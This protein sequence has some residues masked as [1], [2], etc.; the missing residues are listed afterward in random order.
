TG[1]GP[2][3]TA[4]PDGPERPRLAVLVVFDQLRGD[5]LERW[6]KLFV[7]GGFRRFQEEGAWF[8]NCH[9]PYAA[10]LTAAGHASMATG[11][12]PS[13]H[14]IIANEWY[15][16]T[17]RDTVHSARTERHRQVPEP[18]AATKRLLGAAPLRRRRP[19][20]ADVLHKATMGKAKLVSLS[21]KERSAILLAAL[22]R[23]QLCLWFSTNP[24]GFVTS[25]YYADALPPWVERFNRQRPADKWFGAQWT[26]LRPDLNYAAHSGPDDVAAEGIGYAQG[27]TFPH[28]LTGGK[29]KIGPDYYD[30]WANS[31]FASEVLLAL[32][33]LAIDAE[34]LGRD[35]VP[36]LLCLSFASND[37]IGHAWG[38]DSQEVLDVT[39]RSDLLMKELLDFLDARVGKGRYVVAVCSDHGVCPIPELAKAQGKDAA[40]V[41][42]QLLTT[43]ALAFLNET[44]RK[45]GERLPWIEAVSGPEI[46]L[47]RAVLRETGLPAAKVEE[48]L[49]RWLAKQP[50]VQAAYTRTRLSKGPLKDDPIGES[51]RLSFDSERSGD[52][53]V[54]LRPYHLLSGPITSKLDA[55]RTTHG[56][57][58]PYD[59]HVPLL[60]YGPGVVAGARE[61]RITPLAVAPILS[62]AL[63]IDPPAGAEVPVPKGL[64]K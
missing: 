38:P 5:Y 19:A 33:K 45:D 21:I 44:F 61:E 28:P 52:V 41:P 47:N 27:R 3:A 43:R 29:D 53:I 63:G 32:A 62:R 26:R 1:Q 54:V 57:P 35:D 7:K 60:V 22:L 12:T 11:S 18:V 64:F 55:Y 17:I 8:R 48:A 40:R 30:A 4:Q 6:Q 13:S 16:R 36:D 25:T 23:G 49:A 37:L 46:Y 10:T 9:Y 2:A 31:P 56:T 15:D 14:G 58:H 42:P 24:S 20:V 50:G 39:L 34:G 59:T 51:V